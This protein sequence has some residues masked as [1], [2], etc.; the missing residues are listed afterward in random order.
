MTE[1]IFKGKEFVYNHHLSVPFS[2]LVVHADKS[3]G[4]PSLDGNLIIDGD[5]LLALK[6]LMPLYAG[7]VD[8][9]F[10]DPPYNTGKENWCYND[11]VNSPMISTWLSSNPI[12]I[13]DGLRHDKWCSMMWPRLRLLHE[14]LASDG[15]FLMHIDE[16]ELD[17]AISMI[18]E[19]FGQ[20]PVQPEYK[21]L[22]GHIV[23]DKKNPKGD[24][25]GIS[26]QHEFIIV[27]A[28]CRSKTLNRHQLKRR[29]SNV[30][31]MCE[32]GAR[33]HSKI[34]NVV[35]PKD[36]DDLIK[37][38]SLNLDPS[39][40]SYTYDAEAASTDFAEWIAV[41]D[42]LTNGERAYK[43]LDKDGEV[44][45]LVHMGWPNK[46]PAPAEYFKPIK[47]PVTGKDCRVPSRGWRYPPETI[48]ELL[49]SDP[50]V[51]EPQQRVRQG[52]IVFG[53][54][55]NSQPRR[56]YLLSENR[57]ENVPSIVGFGGSDD[58]FLA[59]IGIDFDNP[60]P[61]QFI[62]DLVLWTTQENDLIL[63]SFAGSGTLGHAV[64]MA[65]ERDGGNRRFIL[66][67]M[68]EGDGLAN[69]D[70]HTAERVRR[71]IQSESPVNNRQV[72]RKSNKR[73]TFCSLGEPLELDNLLC[74]KSLPSYVSIGAP[75]F[76]MT[77]NTS[78]NPECVR[79]DDFYLGKA[80]NKHVWLLYRPD[81]KWLKT[82]D[83]A[84]TLERAE[85]FA[86]FAPKSQHVVIAAAL[87]V[88]RRLL[89]EREI[90]V[91]YVPLPFS[92]FGFSK[93]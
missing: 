49:G 63:D 43:L 56:K 93:N 57:I 32:A 41:Q 31:L 46:K 6:S 4:D 5:N 86:N 40:Y 75:L 34:G 10:I 21:N 37:K 55:E 45:Q 89:S 16:N 29:K 11:N 67:Q 30:D 81:L 38:Y 47:H 1:I 2:P 71:V 15:I 80:N 42:H 35:V 51:H 65:N 28:K 26:Y 91:E 50:L 69:A 36:L 84:L 23:W 70:S 58:N 66:I 64:M 52:E 7:K 79:E 39:D 87:F 77:T 33:F 14:L 44:Y 53:L 54:D 8:C 90:P 68:D 3:I 73:F 76:H 83:A 25:R 61:H 78:L 60:K 88:N 13:E 48:E 22:L 82:S 74:G 12:G 85:E 62:S 72:Q 18:D 24:A 92:L 27:A 17:R 20:D 19:I 59:N 9:I